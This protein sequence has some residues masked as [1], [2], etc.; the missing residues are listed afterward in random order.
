MSP[1]SDL[2]TL[3]SCESFHGDKTSTAQQQVL[4]DGC[5]GPTLKDKQI[6]NTQ[7]NANVM[8]LAEVKL[9]VIRF[10]QSNSPFGIGG[11]KLAKFFWRCAER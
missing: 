4:C 1:C 2:N 9:F 6:H 8:S 7:Y 10:Q 11:Y 5:R 3:G